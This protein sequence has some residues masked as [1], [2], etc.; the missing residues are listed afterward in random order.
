[1]SSGSTSQTRYTGEPKNTSDVQPGEIMCD[2]KFMLDRTREHDA[3]GIL[4]RL[5]GSHDGNVAVIDDLVEDRA[6]LEATRNLL[7]SCPARLYFRVEKNGNLTLTGASICGVRHAVVP[8]LLKD[9][10]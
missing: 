10:L 4:N 6:Y 7:R 5:W 8:S 2:V 3:L 1:M 9:S